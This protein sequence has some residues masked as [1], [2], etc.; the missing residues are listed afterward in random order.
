MNTTSGILLVGKS[1]RRPDVLEE[2]LK[3][4][5]RKPEHK[6]GFILSESFTKSEREINES[7]SLKDHTLEQGESSTEENIV[8]SGAQTVFTNGRRLQNVKP[9]Q[10]SLAWP[11][12]GVD[13]LHF[14]NDGPS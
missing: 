9:I 2:E 8:L 14:V 13:G 4:Q 10:K 5:S 12:E 7:C 3:L 6:L 11:A 1:W